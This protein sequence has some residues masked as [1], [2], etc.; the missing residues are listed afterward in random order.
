MNILP[1]RVLEHH[2]YEEGGTP[3]D[4]LFGTFYAA[5]RGKNCPVWY[6]TMNDGFESTKPECMCPPG[7]PKLE[8]MF[9]GLR[10]ES[11]TEKVAFSA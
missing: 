11:I 2:F 6:W 1:G 10:A 3:N 4:P 5:P 9:I 7:F 8:V